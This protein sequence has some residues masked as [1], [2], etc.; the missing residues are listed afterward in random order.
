[1]KDDYKSVKK[2]ARKKR[3]LAIR[4]G[5]ADVAEDARVSASSMS[6]AVEQES[7]LSQPVLEDQQTCKGSCEKEGNV[8]SHEQNQLLD[9]FIAN[10]SQN[11][12]GNV[13]ED[14]DKMSTSDGFNS[15]DDSDYDEDADEMSESDE[16]DGYTDHSSKRTFRFE[17]FDEYASND[18]AEEQD[19]RMEEE[20]RQ[21]EQRRATFWTHNHGRLMRLFLHRQ[22]VPVDS[23]SNDDDDDDEDY[24]YDEDNLHDEQS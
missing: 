16:D 7:D 21:L 18:E 17:D 19:R 4:E 3:D 6:M 24:V 5:S 11:D 22:G 15:E 2:A 12:D 8:E 1:M 23:L 13:D 9:D 14:F 20:R 10:T